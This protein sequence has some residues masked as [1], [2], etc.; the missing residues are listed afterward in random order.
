MFMYK[1]LHIIIILFLGTLTVNAQ[2]S[3]AIDTNKVEIANEYLTFKP[4]FDYQLKS[5]NQFQSFDANKLPFFCRIEHLIESKSKI[6]FRFRL[7][8]LNYVNMLENKR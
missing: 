5:A 4:E 1:Y 3:L 8:D 6:A 7:G 2:M